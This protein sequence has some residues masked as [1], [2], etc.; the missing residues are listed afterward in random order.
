MT[1]E[2]FWTTVCTLGLALAACWFLGRFLRPIPCGSCRVLL[3]GR[4]DGGDLEQAVRALIWLRSVG[5]LACPIVIA[6]LGLSPEGRELA[7]RLIARW[8][9][10]ALW[11]AEDLPDFLTRT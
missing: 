9:A 2:I 1:A 6:D 3:S 11:P 7:L 8:P 10:V 5:L 4:G